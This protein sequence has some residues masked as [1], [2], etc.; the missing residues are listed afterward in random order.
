MAEHN[1]F[2]LMPAA[3][4]RFG[5]QVHQVPAAAWDASTPCT[6][7]SVRDLV[8]HVTAEQLWAPHLL[9][10]ET[11]DEVGDRY[12]G[13]QLGADPTAVWDRAAED[14]RKAWES[15][16][17]DDASVH[18]S[19]GPLPVREYAEQM[20]LDLVVHGWDLARGAGLD[21]TLPAEAAEHVLAFVEPRAE[22]FSG[23]GVFGPPVE[24]DSTDPADRLLAL[25]GR[26]PR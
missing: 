16:A 4:Q 25:L 9:R 21:P 17:R 12:D 11:L 20:H 10:G 18:T 22:E 5:A 13:D 2:R 3:L 1:V 24:V 6:Q 26:D 23:H 15:L 7:W 14:A 8:N 19:M